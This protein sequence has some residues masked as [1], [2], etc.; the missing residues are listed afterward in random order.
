M[1][2]L[3]VSSDR[4]LFRNT[5]VQKYGHRLNHLLPPRKDNDIELRPAGHEFLLLICNYELHSSLYV[6]FVTF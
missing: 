3:L 1:E 2:H 5:C 4:E 6:V